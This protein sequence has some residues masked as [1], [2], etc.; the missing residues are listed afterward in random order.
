MNFWQEI[1]SPVY[2]LAPMEDVTDT[3][4]RELILSISSLNKLHLLFTEFTSV[5]GLLHSKGREVVS[6]RL[7]ISP[8]ERELLKEK[9]VKIIAQ[10][11][12][13]D[14]ENFFQASK[15]IKEEYSFDGIDINMGCPVKKIVK[16]GGCSA[17]IL[18]PELS[19][20]IIHAAKEGSGMPVSVKTRIGFDRVET[21]SW[22]RNL[23]SADPSAI[24]IHG[25][26]RKM[27]SEGLADWN[28]LAKAVKIRDDSGSKSKILGNGDILSLE[29]SDSKIAEYGVDGVMIGR[30]IF[31]N[32][33]L[34]SEI[35]GERS[36]EEKIDLLL[37]HTSLF[38]KQWGGR[39]NFAILRRFFKIYLSGFPGSAGLRASLME[40]HNIS[41]VIE[42]LKDEVRELQENSAYPA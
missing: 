13:S 9:K 6:Q 17:L 32:P 26:T 14:P 4:F 29:E 18:Q 11:W 25:R 22:I 20:E 1:K 19:K 42:S 37:K 15:I 39:K 40:T 38:T 34:F 12:G 30:G 7:L 27:Q 3:V 2:S 31:H 23:L 10:L 35:P 41:E 24:I 21:D 28:E 16:Q 5:D 8:G 33:W 36:K